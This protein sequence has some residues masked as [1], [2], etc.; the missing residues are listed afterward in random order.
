MTESKTVQ[1][2]P[3]AR[4]SHVAGAGDGLFTRASENLA[5]GSNDGLADANHLVAAALDKKALEP[6]LLDVRALCSY[7]SYILL[8]SGRSDRQV[9]AI[10]ENLVAAMRE[11]GVRPLGTEGQGSGQWVLLD[12]GDVIVHVFRHTVREHYDLEGLWID[13]KRVPLILPDEAK[14]PAPELY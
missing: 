5:E 9:D 11:R 8:V 10:A 13:A 7:T 2:I 14:V 3:I 4:D 6:V 1:A 12:F